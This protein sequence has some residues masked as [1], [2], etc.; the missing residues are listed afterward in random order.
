MVGEGGGQW[1]GGRGT[2]VIGEGYVVGEG[3]GQGYGGRGTGVGR[4]GEQG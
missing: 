1:Y 3:G 2:G 4:E